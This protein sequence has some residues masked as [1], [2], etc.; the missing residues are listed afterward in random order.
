MNQ[1]QCNF[2]ATK[3]SENDGKIQLKITNH[4]SR[5]CF[6]NRLQNLDSFRT[7]ES[8]F[9]EELISKFVLECFLHDN[10]VTTSQV[11]KELRK[12]H[13]N[14]ILSHP[15]IQGRLSRLRQDN[16]VEVYKHMVRSNFRNKSTEV[17]LQMEQ[18][19]PTRKINFLYQQQPNRR[20]F[21]CF[22]S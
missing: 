13:P 10:S 8:F 19:G 16:N 15:M 12:K 2:R 14:L 17:S 1:N 3:I 5:K 7:N 18:F 22:F 4:H 11:F 6:K 20:K 9:N 21:T